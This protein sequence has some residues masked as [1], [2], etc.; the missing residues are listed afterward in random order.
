MSIQIN[1]YLSQANPEKYKGI[2]NEYIL[3]SSSGNVAHILNYGAL[4]SKLWI[5]DK[6][7][8]LDDVMLGLK[9]LDEYMASGSNHGSV[10]GRSANR[11]KGARFEINGTE[12]KIPLNDGE[13][14]LHSGSPA[15]QNVFWEG[16]VLK[17]ADASE[18]IKSSGIR[19]LS[20]NDGEALLLSYV[21]PDGACGFPGNLETEVL[22]AWL[23]DNTLFIMYRAVSDKDTVFGPTNHSYF[24]I[25]GHNSGSVAGQ[26]VAINSDYVTYKD[27][28]NC[29]NGELMKVEGTIFDFRNECDVVK[30][31]TLDDPQTKGSL[32]IDQNYCLNPSN[33]YEEAP[34][35]TKEEVLSQ[36]STNSMNFA[37]TIYDEKS[38]RRM[39][40]LTDMPGMHVYAGNHLGGNDQKGDIPYKQYGGI[41]FEAQMYPNAVNEPKF[42][43][44]VIKANDIIYHACGYRFN[45]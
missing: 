42:A 14:N 9:G 41:C 45:S 37:G 10:V 25:A 32:G 11:I 34:V 30:V 19:G 44:S 6:N 7:G 3:T 16:A 40:I 28:T 35:R 43:T 22:Y 38:G 4:I 33:S 5:K 12:Y 20:E 15:F 21:S 36:K 17:S 23:K 8:N 2:S 13:N 26:K 39:D 1:E 31:L 27:D 24:N 18:Y 29:P